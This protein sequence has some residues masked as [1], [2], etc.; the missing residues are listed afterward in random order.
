MANCPDFPVKAVSEEQFPNWI[1]VSKILFDNVIQLIEKNYWIDYIGNKGVKMSLFYS[2]KHG[3][4]NL[5]CSVEFVL[6]PFSP[7]DTY[8]GV[9]ENI[10]ESGFCLITHHPLVE[11]QEITIKS[12]IYLPAEAATVC[13]VKFEDD[14]Y[15]AGMR[16]L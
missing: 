13:W 10:S 12:L 9:I 14:F 11:G 7:D 15:T 1:S 16:F 3:R 5:Q 8:K 6:D 4:C 2:A